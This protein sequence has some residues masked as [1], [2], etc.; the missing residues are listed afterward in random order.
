MIKKVGVAILGLGV[1]GGGTYETLTAHHD[2][3]LKNQYHQLSI[4]FQQSLF[5]KVQ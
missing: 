3:Y 2:F 1:V 5:C 4:I